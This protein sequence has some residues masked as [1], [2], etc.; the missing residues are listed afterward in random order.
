VTK[1]NPDKHHRRSVRLQGYDYSQNGAYFV[2]ICAFNRECL[3]GEVVNEMMLLNA[4]GE[5]VQEEWL[6]S[7]EIR[8]EIELDLFVVM[9]NHFH[10]IIVLTGDTV[11][12]NRRF[13]PTENRPSGTTSGSVSAIIQ[14]YKS[15]VTKRINTMRDTPGTPV[16]QRSFHNRIIR[17]EEALNK[18]RQ[19]VENNPAR[20]AFDEENPAN[21]RPS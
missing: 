9:P 7:A 8:R 19:Y 21:I 10:G 20:W 15:I 18:A 1:Y 6:R 13:A 16:W 12:A 4:W 17:N 11:G 5:I 2:T 14:Q 3:F